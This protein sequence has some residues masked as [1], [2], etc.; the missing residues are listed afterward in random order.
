MKKKITSMVNAVLMPAFIFAA[1]L[2][3]SCTKN[4]LEDLQ[5]A[6]FG[7]TTSIADAADKKTNTTD[8]YNPVPSIPAD[9]MIGIR[10]G[11]CMGMCP[12]YQV[13]LTRNGEVTYTGIRN[14]RV[15]GTV[16]YTVSPDVAYQLGYM[17]EKGGFFT[18]AD[19]Y[20]IIPDAQRFETSLVWNGKIKTVVDYGINVP[21]SLVVMRERV[22]RAL[23]IDRLI[24]GDPDNPAA[25]ATY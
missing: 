16:H 22:E 5:I 7:K 21:P 17:M 9:A 4:E 23:N 24:K 19:A 15:I 13:S 14:V 20:V 10:H 18:F 8:D 1:L 2:F 25:N 12:N 6:N 11:A 3:S